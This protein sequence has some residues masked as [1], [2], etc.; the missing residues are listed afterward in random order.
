MTGGEFPRSPPPRGMGIEIGGIMIPP[1]EMF[2]IAFIG[3]Y[4]VLSKLISNR[5]KI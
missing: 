1:I 3:L 4:A 5:Q 2:E